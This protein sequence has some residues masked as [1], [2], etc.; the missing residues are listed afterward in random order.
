[1]LID[2]FLN[3]N[4]ACDISALQNIE[5]IRRL[6]QLVLVFLG[7]AGV[8][9]LRRAEF[10]E[11]CQFARPQLIFIVTQICDISALQSIEKRVSLQHL[12]LALL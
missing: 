4:H 8:R 5:G 10:G 1:V 11:G 6:Q 12:N 3:W 9:R 2:I 7:I